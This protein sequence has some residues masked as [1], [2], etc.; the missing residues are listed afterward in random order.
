VLRPRFIPNFSLVL[1]YYEISIDD[2]IAAVTADT[3]AANCVSGATLNTD[4]CSTIF[5]NNP[6]I[7]FGVGA[8]AGDPDR[9]LHRAVVQLRLAQ[10]PRSGL[11]ARYKIDTEEM[12]GRNYGQ[13]DY[14]I[15]GSWLITQQQYLNESDPSDY[16]ELAGTLFYPRVRFHLVADL[17]AE[18][19]L[20]RQLDGGL[21]TAQNIVY[22]RDLISNIDSREASQ[23]NTGQLRPQR[24][25]LPLERQ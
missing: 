17:D 23:L 5:R 6:N 22:P 13:L 21:A 10:D 18:R 3:A 15:A 25:H 9:R 7:P 16:D 24:L 2:V 14:S 19:D 20:E 8:P 12:F 11:H 4:A 1:D